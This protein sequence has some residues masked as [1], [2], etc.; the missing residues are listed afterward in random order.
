VTLT[1]LGD[2]AQDKVAGALA[3]SALYLKAFGHCVI[4]WRWLEQAVHAELGLLKADAGERDFYL[5]KLQ[6]ARYFLTWEVPGCHNELA[7][8][9]ARDDTCLA[10]QDEW[11]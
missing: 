6:A 4:G 10:M 8:L 5:G 11:F 3:N 2:L 7:L 1:L 9:E